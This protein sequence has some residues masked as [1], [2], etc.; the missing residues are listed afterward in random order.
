MKNFCLASIFHHDQS[1]PRGGFKGNPETVKIMTPVCVPAPQCSSHACGG[2]LVRVLVAGA[3]GV[4]LHV[5]KPH[6]PLRL[7]EA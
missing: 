6:T 2:K 7:T 4:A 1:H 3:A 5:A